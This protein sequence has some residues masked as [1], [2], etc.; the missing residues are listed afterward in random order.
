MN[1]IPIDHTQNIAILGVFVAALRS[2]HVADYDSRTVHIRNN[3]YFV[4][5][6]AV[7]VHSAAEL[8]AVHYH[9]LWVIYIP[10]SNFLYWV[11]SVDANAEHLDRPPTV[12][13]TVTAQV[14][15]H[16]D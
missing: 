15:G 12:F 5:S 11:E 3:Q 16:L 13:P 9:Y 1:G 8:T 7:R 4:T 10:A 6:V 14:E 2:V